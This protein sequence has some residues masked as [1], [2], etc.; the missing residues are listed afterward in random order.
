MNT[1]SFLANI[2]DLIARDD[3]SAALSQLRSLLENSPKLD[4][5]LLQSA[6]FQDIQKQIRLGTVSHAEA[7]L[8]QN[9]I[10]D[11]L[12]DLL[13]EFERSV[14]VT[15][16]YPDTKESEGMTSSHTLT[17]ALR[18]E[19][20]R[21]IS[22]VNSKNVVAGSTISA[23]GG[24]HIG[25]KKTE[26]H[27]HYGDRKIP[28]ALTQNPFQPE[29]FIGREQDVQAIHDKLF[30]PG[31]NLLLL[32]N[33][34]GGVGKTTLASKYYHRYQD[35]YAHSAWV[36]SEKNLANALLLLALPL[37]LS[38][39][40]RMPETERLQTLL[41]EMAALERPCL[42][43]I[44][45]A[46]ELED[47][48]K[49]YQNLRRC[50][51]FHLLITSRI[52]EFGKAEHYPVEGLPEPEALQL[53]RKYYP[54][55]QP[56]EEVIFKEIRTAVGGNTLVVELLAKNLALFN[57][58]KTRYTLPDLLADLQQKGLLRLSQSQ[59]VDTDYQSQGNTMRRE[60]PEDIIAAMYDLG[61]LPSEETAL[62]SVLAVLP[63]ESIPF[64]TL[65]T[66]LPEQNELDTR[67]L[68]LA[69]KGWIEY[70]ETDA[71]FKISPV[72]Q[73]IARQKNPNLSADCGYLVYTLNEKLAYEPGTGHFINVG[74]EEAGHFARFAETLLASF[75]NPD[76]K[77][78][79][80]C[81]RTGR[82]H[83]TTGNLERAFFF[84]EKTI[85]I[86]KSLCAAE[87]DNADFKNDLAISYQHL[88]NTYTALGDLEKALGYYEDQVRL[89]EELY[90]AYPNNVSFK[91][92]LAV[93]YYKLGEFSRDHQ[94]NKAQAKTY[95]Q[96][97]ERLWGELVRDAPQVVQYQRFLGIVQ[98]E[99][100]GL[101]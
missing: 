28:R 6:R 13:R 47:L 84:F 12:L 40:E 16:S 50:S 63:A 3:L 32:V 101:E 94:N 8:T 91:N 52:T 69:K 15:Q 7:N 89:F 49:H 5:A 97:A 25:E 54:K 34:H 96:Q 43:V 56:E 83:Q 30:T 36:L 24:I 76:Y 77:L 65:E 11:G 17:S 79:T 21:A 29:V 62:L 87:P 57:R 37:G 82:Y 59:A 22:I 38:F 20:E 60:K 2:R 64:T 100:S 4:E 98:E 61:E 74:Y 86:D 75:D 58:L 39:D 26:T 45:N 73:E 85:E 70:S 67:L 41:R 66:L 78:S 44:D 93:S 80:L 81:E 18:E 23:G 10:R 27:H 9:Q 68:S 95:F 99:L 90:A 31:S 35:E 33:G 92:G 48:E 1:Q 72:V 55:L 19:M 42:L 71:S 51:N 14:G 46:N 53:F 88:G